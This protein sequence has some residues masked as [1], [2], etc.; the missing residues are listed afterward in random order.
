MPRKRTEANSLKMGRPKT[1][2]DIYCARCDEKIKRP[3]RR[4]DFK[5]G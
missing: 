4:K 3:D 5:E 1:A 2:V